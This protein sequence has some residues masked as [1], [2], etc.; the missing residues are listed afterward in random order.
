[1]T[2]LF[3]ITGPAGLSWSPG[4]PALIVLLLLCAVLILTVTRVMRRLSG[5]SGIT[6]L[7]V[8]ALNVATF[9]TVA[10]LLVP[11]ERLQE[12]SDAA[13]LLTPGADTADLPRDRMVYSL[14]GVEIPAGD[15]HL[16][17]LSLPGQLTLREP[18]LAALEI[19]GH[20][21]RW[22]QWQQLPTD[23]RVGFE[24]APLA[25][26]TDVQWPRLLHLGEP[27]SVTG[28]LTLPEEN[29]VAR[30]VLMDPAGLAVAETTARSGQSFAVESVP[31]A[32][33]RMTYTLQSW[34]GDTLISEEPVSTFVQANR[35]ARLLIVQSAPSF[36]TRQLVNWAA[37]RGQEAVVLTGIS[38]DRDLA[39]GFN[40][41]DALPLNLNRALLGW[42]D[43][44]IMDGRRWSTLSAAQAGL[45]LD[46]VSGGA[47]LLLLADSQLAEW[48]QSQANDALGF[49]LLP[50]E[51][52]LAAWPAWP[53]GAPATP[54]PLAPWR[55]DNPR[56]GAAA[57]T[58]TG[59]EE[60]LV[61]EAWQALGA[62]RVAISLIRERQ[63]WFTEGQAGQATRYWSYLMRTLGRPVSG[64]EWLAPASRE[65]VRANRVFGFCIA[66]A[67][68][69][70]YLLE[71]TNG[72]MILEGEMLAHADG[73]PVACG[74]A[75]VKQAGWY[76]LKLQ[77]GEAG[78]GA[79]ANRELSVRVFA[80]QEWLTS[81]Y[82]ARQAAT[83]ARAR[84]S[85]LP[86]NDG[87]VMVRSPAFSPWWPFLTLLLAASLLWLERRLFD[88]K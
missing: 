50:A 20:G 30:L 43:L 39:Q 34:L 25:G 26:P 80:E 48:L 1:M 76:T 24:P 56:S 36:D 15:N 75:R 41:P 86:E 37:D 21:L 87:T 88:L 42:A 61:L 78:G 6:R 84:G 16:Q 63:R 17:A 33:G 13:L 79:S 22:Q 35:G 74:R 55:L 85:A 3:N 81:E 58:L 82:A 19:R 5:A 18:G 32:S 14:P 64:P 53:G 72:D 49:A 73:F 28:A 8:V 54:L 51:P 10:L 31:R 60:G 70:A 83:R 40:T 77:T 66:G 38:R 44:I 29:R 23:L 69:A 2:P 46:A 67:G 52:G 45:V 47:G 68:P 4:L 71:S 7:L 62:G 12:Q 11:P 59:S 9:C 65:M 57:H 27:L